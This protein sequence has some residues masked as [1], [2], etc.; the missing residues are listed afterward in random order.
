MAISEYQ[1]N[2]NSHVGNKHEKHSKL[3]DDESTKS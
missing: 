2:E 1:L 3:T